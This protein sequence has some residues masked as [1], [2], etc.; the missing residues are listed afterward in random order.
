MAVAPLRTVAVLLPLVLHTVAVLPIDG[1]QPSF[2]MATADMPVAVGAI[3]RLAVFFV[4]AV[5]DNG[6]VWPNARGRLRVGDAT[7]GDVAS[8]DGDVAAIVAAIVASG[9]TL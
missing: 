1:P 2:P 3:C 4:A 7:C 6:G 8:V 5:G 9:V